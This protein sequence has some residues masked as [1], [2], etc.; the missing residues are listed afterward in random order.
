MKNHVD[1]Q[2]KK[3][4]VKEVLLLSDKYELEYYQNNINKEYD[5]IV[6]TRKDNKKI[7][8]TSN[9]IP[10]EINENLENNTKVNIKIT[11]VND[12]K[13]IGKVI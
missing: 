13:I 9:Y 11:E 5:G 6:E 4:R 10:V 8:I 2:V 1:G 3:C 12:S 7:V